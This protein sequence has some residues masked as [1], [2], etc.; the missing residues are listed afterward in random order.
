M[1]TGWR[2]M[3]TKIETEVEMGQIGDGRSG[4]YRG[5]MKKGRRM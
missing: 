3:L 5:W 1:V 2:I 4:M